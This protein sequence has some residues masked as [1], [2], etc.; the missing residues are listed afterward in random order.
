MLH[1]TSLCGISSFSFS[2]S[3]PLILS[4]LLGR[5][6]TLAT[7][8]LQKVVGFRATAAAQRVRLILTLSK[9]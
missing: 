8:Q 6:A 5:V 3:T 4:L 9:Q 1:S 2:Y 7:G